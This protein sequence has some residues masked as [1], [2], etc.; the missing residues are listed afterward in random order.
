MKSGLRD[1][2]N[3]LLLADGKGFVPKVS[4]KSGLRD[5]N[6]DDAA[7]KLNVTKRSQ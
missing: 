7:R 1:R 6:N 3:G 4:M 5:R 2:N